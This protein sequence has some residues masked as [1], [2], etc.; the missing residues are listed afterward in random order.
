MKPI[1]AAIRHYRSSPEFN[2]DS[3]PTALLRDHATA[4][5]VWAS[6]VVLEGSVRYAVTDAGAERADYL[7]TPALSGT[8]LPRQVHHLEIVG[9]VRFRV[10]FYR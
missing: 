4:D 2:Q 3:V 1:P 7:L 9:P 8:V 10:D 5:G 6:V